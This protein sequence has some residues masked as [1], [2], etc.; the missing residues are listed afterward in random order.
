MVFPV[1]GSSKGPQLIEDGLES[2]ARRPTGDS[3]GA[4]LRGMPPKQE[5]DERRHPGLLWCRQ[6][7]AAL[8]AAGW[9]ETGL[10]K[11]PPVLDAGLAFLHHWRDPA[12]SVELGDQGQVVFTIKRHGRVVRQVAC[13]E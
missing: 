11:R 1:I 12:V 13:P 10:Y 8:L 2:D 9:T 6:H 4:T 7:E 3:T 5:N